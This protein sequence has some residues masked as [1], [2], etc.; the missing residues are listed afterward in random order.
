[1]S[2]K[3]GR[4]GKIALLVVEVDVKLDEDFSVLLNMV[5][6]LVTENQLR[7]ENAILMNVQVC[8]VL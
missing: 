4:N 5:A 7:L 1:M 3:I 8:F 2:G 6:V